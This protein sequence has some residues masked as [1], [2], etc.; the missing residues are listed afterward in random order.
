V[1]DTDGFFA[2]RG[3][4]VLA[5]A[6]LNLLRE[7]LVWP[8]LSAGVTDAT[9]QL[10]FD[11]GWYI[12]GSKTLPRDFLQALT[13]QNV[14][15]KIHLGYGGGLY[16]KSA[17][18][19]LELFSPGPISGLAEVDRGRVNLGARYSRSGWSVTAAL[20]ELRKPGATISYSFSVR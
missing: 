6:K 14:A 20:F 18:A 11:P 16:D 10:G 3:T 9:D 15:L 2:R 5:N 13:G 1:V 17:F 19:G 4:H 12:V 8:A 7:T